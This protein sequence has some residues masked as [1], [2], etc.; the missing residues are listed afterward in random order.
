MVK[1][2]IPE[3]G[4]FKGL[5]Y[6]IMKGI[7]LSSIDLDLFEAELA[8]EYTNAHITPIAIVVC[9]CGKDNKKRKVFQIAHPAPTNLENKELYLLNNT[10]VTKSDIDKFQRAFDKSIKREIK[11][12]C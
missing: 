2:K 3:T 8:S 5:K 9:T 7:D 12:E 1:K 11:N 6:K 4:T 10:S